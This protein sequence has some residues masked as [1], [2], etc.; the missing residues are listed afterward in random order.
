MTPTTR[1]PVPAVSPLV[2][3]TTTLYG[4]LLRIGGDNSPT[5]E[6]RFLD[7]EKIACKVCSV[8]LARELAARLYEIIGVR[9]TASWATSDMSLQDFRIEHLTGYRQTSLTE[10]FESLRELA[11]E[12]YQKIGDIDA[13]V[14]DLRGREPE[15]E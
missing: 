9:G 10:A 13:F 7:D 5:A 8:D 4:K 14:A 2:T 12:H 3:G 6:V 1:F 11:E 15:D